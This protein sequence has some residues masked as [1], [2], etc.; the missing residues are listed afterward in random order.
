MTSGATP[1]AAKASRTPATNSWA[2]LA[3]R[4]A[5]VATNLTR[6]TPSSEH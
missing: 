3:S 6:S 5:E 2:L 1:K 4:D